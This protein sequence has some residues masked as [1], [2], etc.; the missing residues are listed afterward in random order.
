MNILILI[1][2]FSEVLFCLF[3]DFHRFRTLLT[4]GIMLSLP[5]TFILVISLI[6][7]EMLDFIPFYIPGLWIW[8]VGFA[9]FY[10]AECGM[11]LLFIHYKESIQEDYRIP[12]VIYY[13]ILI[14]SL[15]FIFAILT[16]GLSVIGTKDFA[17]ELFQGGLKGRFSNLLL[18]IAPL[19]FWSQGKILL[20]S[21]T[22][23]LFLFI[24]PTFGSKTYLIGSIVA[25][26][27]MGICRN[28]IKFSLPV[29]FS[30]C[31]AGSG[32]FFL[33]YWLLMNTDISTF[34]LWGTRHFFFY[35]T[36]GILPL[37][38][39]IQQDIPRMS[40]SNFPFYAL[41]SSWGF[42]PPVFSE[43]EIWILTD[44]I[45][46]TESNVFSFFGSIYLTTTDS[47]SFILYS[48]FWGI[49]S[50]LFFNIAYKTK[51]IFFQ[52]AWSWI[53]VGLFFG[54]FGNQLK[55]LRFW[56]IL[57]WGIFLYC[58]HIHFLCYKKYNY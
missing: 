32:G 38:E 43:S 19:V 25:I 58:L 50:S 17:S 24:L 39:I 46:L 36:S 27:F 40:G 53:L 55:L 42:C 3:L 1:I 16:N 29:I 56:E 8:I 6:F 45:K 5:F 51:N 23:A 14:V 47:F 12:T 41:L 48:A 33:Y 31:I 37:G 7:A 11:N 15:F 54:W 28:K 13:G 44:I 9:T 20:K 35:L 49:F 26:V 2:F 52:V 22:L 18:L 30:F 4:P 10:L 34:F 57:I 21:I